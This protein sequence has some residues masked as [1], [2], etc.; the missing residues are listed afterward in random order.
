MCK[1]FVC[2]GVQTQMFVVCYEIDM[3]REFSY[4]SSLCSQHSDLYEW[5]GAGLEI[6]HCLPSQIETCFFCGCVV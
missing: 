3:A 6:L 4:S 2:F 5:W 1:W